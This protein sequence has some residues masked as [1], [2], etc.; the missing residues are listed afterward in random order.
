MNIL[1]RPKFW[2]RLVSVAALLGAGWLV[3][4]PRTAAY[5]VDDE[6]H[7]Y[8]MSV[9][10][11]WDTSDQAMILPGGL[12]EDDD[13]GGQDGL[14]SMVRLDCGTAFTAGENE[15]RRSADGQEACSEV[16]TPRRFFGVCLILL[17]SAGLWAAPRLP[18]LR[19]RLPWAAQ[20]SDVD[21]EHHLS[22]GPSAPGSHQEPD[23][24]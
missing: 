10:Y 21:K 16:E 13:S 8:D 14:V 17:G 3:L 24:G 5:F 11:S 15:D 7:P 23:Q 19:S 4:V 6:G 2:V 22:E 1:R 18:H 12:F 9:L 20:G